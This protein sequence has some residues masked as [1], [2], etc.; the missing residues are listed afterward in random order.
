MPPNTNTENQS[1]RN[2]SSALPS[3]RLPFQPYIDNINNVYRHTYHP[4]HSFLGPLPPSSDQA[5]HDFDTWNRSAHGCFPSQ[6][7]CG[8][9]HAGPSDHD[10]PP[11]PRKRKQAASPDPAEVGGYGPIPGS[12]SERTE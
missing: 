5:I 2:P 3:S 4:E 11:N 1:H 6:T 10:R 8:P 12:P 9:G 7:L